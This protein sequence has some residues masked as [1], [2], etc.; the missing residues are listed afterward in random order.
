M[1]HQ[2]VRERQREVVEHVDRGDRLVELDRVERR[3]AVAE[4]DNV[5]EVEVAV[6]APHPTEPSAALDQPLLGPARRLRCRL[7]C[8]NLGPESG[9]AGRVPQRTGDLRDARPDILRIAEGRRRRRGAVQ[10]G[11]LVGQPLDDRQGEVS[12]VAQPV[13]LPAAVETAHLDQPVD[14]LAGP[15]EPK[16]AVAS[17]HRRRPQVDFAGRT[18]H[19][20][21]PEAHPLASIERREVEIVGAHGA[22]QLPGPVARQK[23][24]RDVRVDPLHRR[25]TVRRGIRQKGDHLALAGLRREE[26]RLT[27]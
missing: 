27:G 24:P 8:R 25:A 18:V 12:A 4:H 7:P 23:D 1:P 6:T 20:K 19:L 5:A 15:A 17:H 10:R 16:P 2:Q 13:Q 9:A 14:Q 26:P 3:R 21:L 22:L 11:D